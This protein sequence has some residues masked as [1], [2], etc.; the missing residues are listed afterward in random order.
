MRAFSAAALLALAPA[1]FAQA[2]D[3]DPSAPTPAAPGAHIVERGDTLWD[4]S[5]RFLHD[6]W[7]WPKVW[8]YNPGISNPHL[9]HPGGTVRFGPGVDPA[10]VG[11]ALPLPEL[12]RES[13]EEPLPTRELD[14]FSRA[15]MRRP[16]TLGEWD[17]VA[18]SGPYKIGFVPQRGVQA[19]RDTF[20]TPREL[21]E[22]G[23]VTAAFEEKQLLTV[24]DRAYARFSAAGRVRPGE[25]YLLFRTERQVRHPVSKELFGYKSAIIGTARVVAADDRAVTIEI[26]QAFEPVERG[27]FL[28]PWNE[29]LVKRVQ[30]RPNARELS[31]YIIAAGRDS[32]TELGEHHVVFVDKGR[33]DGV[34]EGNVFTVLRSGDPYGEGMNAIEKDTTLPVEKVATLV[35]LDAQQTSSSAIVVRSAREI[36]VGDRVEMR[37]GAPQ[38]AGAR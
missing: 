33:A 17:D 25:S 38:L 11:E 37:T 28:A 32:V 18:V 27:A 15:D 10:A 1:A 2:A 4:L 31:G 34:E 8:S 5:S 6:P 19:R 3:S 14:G 21:A 35:V 12:A 23:V 36:Y 13:A 9:I 26:Q 29:Q 16:Q 20:V 24:G 7:S 22:S 30:P